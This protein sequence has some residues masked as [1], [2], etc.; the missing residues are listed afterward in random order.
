MP[1][2]TEY[3]AAFTVR[4]GVFGVDHLAGRLNALVQG[5]EIAGWHPGRWL[6]WH[7]T[8]IEINFESAA[9]AALAKASCRG[10][11]SESP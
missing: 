6:D 10:A 3:R 1:V 5:R 7:H 8:S 2:V 11:A 9:D 4:H